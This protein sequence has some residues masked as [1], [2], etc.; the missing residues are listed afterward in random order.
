MIDIEILKALYKRIF[1]ED[2]NPN[3]KEH[4][5]NLQNA[6]YILENLGVHVGDY[7][8]TLNK[9]DINYGFNELYKK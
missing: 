6:V 9:G 3:D 7:G 4:R 8:F 1:D 5:Q 2:F